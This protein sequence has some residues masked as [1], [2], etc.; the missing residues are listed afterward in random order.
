MMHV[1]SM[2][3]FSL[4]ADAPPDFLRSLHDEL[5]QHPVQSPFNL[6]LRTPE[7]LKNPLQHWVEDKALD[8]DYHVRR[9]A[10]PAPGDE[11]EL[12][13]LVSRLHGHPVD[14]TRPPWET[15]LIEGLEDAGGR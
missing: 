12:G 4:P 14:F 11:R 1:G 2:L 6:R 10:L 5:R 7:F 13:V 15:H 9:S 8:I 3:P